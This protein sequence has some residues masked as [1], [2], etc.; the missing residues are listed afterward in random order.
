MAMN[1]IDEM[2]I[3]KAAQRL[4]GGY[5]PGS[6]AGQKFS[7]REAEA[8]A[9]RD[10][11]TAISAEEHIDLDEIRDTVRTAGVVGG[12]RSESGGARIP[13][14]DD[15]DKDRM[16]S[17]VAKKLNQI[18]KD[19][20]PGPERNMSRDAVEDAKDRGLSENKMVNNKTRKI[21][22]ESAEIPHAIYPRGGRRGSMEEL[23]KMRRGKGML[24]LLLLS[25][26]GVGGLGLAGA[27]G[28]RGDEA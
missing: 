14:I 8:R 9:I 20:P 16:R 17:S 2:M 28:G 22:R 18:R 10:M 24:P 4:M 3:L 15:L 25:L 1:N 7:S 23:V 11:L 21:F 13:I 6:F 27:A 5:Q 26:L 12:Y 19:F